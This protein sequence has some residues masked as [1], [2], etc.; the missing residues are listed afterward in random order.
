MHD[1]FQFRKAAIKSKL[2]EQT[3]RIIKQRTLSTCSISVS[4]HL[5]LCPPNATEMVFFSIFL[6]FFYNFD[7]KR[8]QK[9]DK[10]TLSV[11][12]FSFFLTKTGLTPL[13]IMTDAFAGD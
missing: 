11:F 3:L 9:L 13:K 1:Q 4:L 8:G 2:R 12:F 10:G 6:V 7:L 5:D